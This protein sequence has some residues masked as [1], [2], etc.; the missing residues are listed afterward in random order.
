MKKLRS[1]IIY[2]IIF[3]FTKSFLFPICSEAVKIFSSLRCVTDKQAGSGKSA[4]AYLVTDGKQTF[5]L[6]VQKTTDKESLEKAETEVELLSR[7]KHPNIVELFDTAI[8]PNYFYIL[9][10]NGEEGTLSMVLRKHPK[11][12]L[13]KNF[14]L[15]IFRQLVEAIEYLHAKGI[16]H[17][18]LKSANIVF[19]NDLR[20]LVIDFDLSVEMGSENIQRGSEVYMDAEFFNTK[21]SIVEYNEMNDVYALGVLLYEMV[22]KKTPFKF[23]NW[24]NLHKLIKDGKIS[25]DKGVDVDIIRIIHDCMQDDRNKRIDIRGL[26]ILVEDALQNPNSVVLEDSVDISNK[27]VLPTKVSV[28]ITVVSLMIPEK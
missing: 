14:I 15:K 4:I 1:C 2:Y 28:W 27:E 23:I 17:A 6:K 22:H 13:D 25:I 18:D 10:E 9:L 11:E 19:T 16:V 5:I 24:K 26:K 20:P 21:S 12:F 8:S 7:L 3:Q